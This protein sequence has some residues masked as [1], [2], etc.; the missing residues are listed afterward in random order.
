M[1]SRIVIVGGGV[2]G[3]ATA[4]A[5]APR[6]MRI[7]VIERRAQTG[8]IHRGDSLLPKSVALLAKW[9][10]RDA[11]AA[12]GARP[13]YRMEI[14]APDGK[15][16]YRVPLTPRRAAHP[17]LVLPHARLEAVLMERALRFAN[18]EVIRPASFVDLLRDRETGR[19][20]GVR[21]RRGDATEEVHCRLVVAADGQHSAVRKRAGIAFDVHRY[22]HAYFGLESDRPPGYRDAMRIHFHA[23]GGALLMPHPDRLGVGILVES[24]SA[25]RWMTMDEGALSNELVKRAPILRGT[26]LHLEGAHVYELSRA[27]A[28]CYASGGIVLIGD[29]AHCTNPTAGQGMA[30]A[31]CDADALAEHLGPRC[32]DDA[33]SLD[34]AARAY[35]SRRWPVNQRLVWGAHWLGKLYALRGPAWTRVK[36]CG[37]MA[38]ARPALHR[39]TRPVIARFILDANA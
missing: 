35:E 4:I 9:G 36:A 23:D 29:A 12:Q 20:C 39:L 11:L 22:D 15:G 7:T 26:A 27:H 14:H 31:L 34:A 2:G 33:Q 10:L 25:R 6:G 24:G 3:L 30:M 32:D 18:V 21:Y 19:V 28:P 1:R 17:Y 5:L 13:I 38:L 8:G 37:V 16:A